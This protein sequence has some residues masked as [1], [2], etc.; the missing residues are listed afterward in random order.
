MTGSNSTLVGGFIASGSETS[1]LTAGNYQNISFTGNTTVGGGY[2]VSLY[3]Q[4]SPLSQGILF[5][6]IP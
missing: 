3:G 1:I 5:Q 4:V 2:G 6:T